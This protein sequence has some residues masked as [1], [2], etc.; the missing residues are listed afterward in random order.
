MDFRKKAVS[1]SSGQKEFRMET[2]PLLAIFLIVLL[3]GSAALVGCSHA[4]TSPVPPANCLF[5]ANNN[6]NSISMF[7]VNTMT[8]E[9]AMGNSMSSG[10]CT[11]PRYLEL[12]PAKP[13]LFLSCQTSSS[14]VAFSVDTASGALSLAGG[15]V[16][17]GAGPITVAVHP[18]GNF[19]YVSNIGSN[20]VSAFDLG[21]DGS[22]AEIALPI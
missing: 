13:L 22:L 18:N 16:A 14:L 17:T 1:G 9:A 21:M 11:G 10:A 5:V 3:A 8:G 12:H 6:L 20:T 2:R 15:P 19:V 4:S 7:P